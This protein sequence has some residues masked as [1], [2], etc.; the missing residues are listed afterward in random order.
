MRAAKGLEFR[1]SARGFRVSARVRRHALQA[2]RQR[3]RERESGMRESGMR[4]S[5]I[6]TVP[7]PGGGGCASAPHYSDFCSPLGARTRQRTYLIFSLHVYTC[8]TQTRAVRSFA[9]ASV[10]ESERARERP[11][12][13]RTHVEVMRA[14]EH[15]RPCTMSRYSMV[16]SLCMLD[17]LE[18]MHAHRLKAMHHGVLSYRENA[19]LRDPA[20]PLPCSL[21]IRH[22]PPH[23]ISLS[24]PLSLTQS[25]ILF[26][27]SL[28]LPRWL[29]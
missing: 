1:V 20:D 29:T 24:F 22:P 18:P 14:A 26:F 25:L 21:L 9:R 13:L 12:R 17:G 2:W 8:S 7:W 5:R 3:E 11:L 16:L 23:T 19:V 10:R 6:L 15:V 28:F 27:S 4:E